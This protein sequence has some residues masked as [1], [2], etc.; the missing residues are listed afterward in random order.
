MIDLDA[1]DIKNI[2]TLKKNPYSLYYEGKRRPVLEYEEKDVDNEPFVLFHC[3][4]SSS[5]QPV[6]FD[7][8]LMI[9]LLHEFDLY[10][11]V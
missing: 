10:L 8:K 3:R 5:K 4:G 9:L 11:W 7:E 1:S 6:D 2:N